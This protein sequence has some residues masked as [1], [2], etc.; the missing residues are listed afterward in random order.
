MFK[1]DVAADRRQNQ[2]DGDDRTGEA[3][4][5][6]KM[7]QG[8]EV[9]EKDSRNGTEKRLDRVRNNMRMHELH[10]FVRFQTR[11]S[12]RMGLYISLLW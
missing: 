11:G 12:L 1:D 5:H 10:E 4:E 8:F 2:V 9:D 3:D 6:W 7:Q